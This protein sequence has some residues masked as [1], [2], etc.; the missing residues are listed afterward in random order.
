MKNSKLILVL[1]ILITFVFTAT[2]CGGPKEDIAV[3]VSAVT[4]ARLEAFMDVT[5]VLVPAQ[6]I[7][8]QS[9]ISGQVM[10]ANFEVG[11][12]VKK[13]DV[14]IA[15]ETKALSIQ[16]E[17]AK[18]SLQSAIAAQKSAKSQAEQAKINLESAEN[19]YDRNKELYD[20]EAISQNEL[21]MAQ[22]KLEIAKFQYQA[23][24]EGASGQS[25][26]AVEA[27]QASVDNIQNQ[28]SEATIKSPIDGIIT[29]KN[30]SVGEIASP[31]VVLLTVIDISTLKLK[32]TIA[33]ESL[34]FINPGQEIQLMVDIYPGRTF[35]GKVDSVG[36]MAVS[37]GLYFPVE[38]S[39]ANSGDL[40]AGLSAHALI[41]MA[42]EEGLVIP[43]AAVSEVNGQSYVFVIKDNT[44][45]KT[46]VVTGL[47][48]D[49]QVQILEGLSAGD[50]VATT[51]IGNLFDSIPVVIENE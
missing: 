14:L 12:Q 22:D 49:E 27:A 45:I 28:I 48:N 21:E 20:A 11:A 6:A 34:P 51:N 13:G 19:N 9:K 39:M 10:A 31:G 15:L 18:A 23:A 41:E 1:I 17:Q 32:S 38:I 44:V 4:E 36:P 42:A 8:V 30:I 47:K 43:L 29:N 40:K 33:Q 37:T 35:T 46:A 50:R 25:Q 5:G 7:D 16:L 3:K 24:L 2:A 26:A